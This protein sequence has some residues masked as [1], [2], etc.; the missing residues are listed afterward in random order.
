MSSV[1]YLWFYNKTASRKELWCVV[2]F[3][4]LELGRAIT[5]HKAG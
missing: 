4:G 1:L 2:F 3:L 5:D